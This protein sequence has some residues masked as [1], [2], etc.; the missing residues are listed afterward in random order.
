MAIVGLVLADRL[1]QCRQ[2]AAGAR[3]RP[4]RRAR[5]PAGH[6]CE[7]GAAHPP[8]ADR[9]SGSRCAGRRR[10]IDCS[11][12]GVPSC[13]WPSSPACTARFFWSRC[14]MRAS[15]RSRPRSRV[16]TG[17]SVQP[18]AG[19]P[20][21]ARR[22]TR[23]GEGNRMSASRPRLRFGQTLVVLQVA[24]SLVLLGGAALFVRTLQNLNRPRRRLQARRRAD[25]ARRCHAREADR[26]AGAGGRA[27]G[28][29][30]VALIWET[31]VERVSRAAGGAGRR[32]GDAQSAQR[33]RSWRCASLADTEAFA[34]KPPGP[35]ISTRS[36][37]VTSM[38][39]A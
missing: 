30:A 26:S 21:H 28:S 32:R 15:S 33:T 16:L 24:V 35:S 31:L 8:D 9:G 19:A 12:D 39:S 4:D 37:L 22:A 25:D 38:P 5:G 36:R 10:R 23:P 11:G 18:R 7:P 17:L 13:S 14:S 20:V 3:E 2:P 27:G 29:R 1:R 6:R 34:S